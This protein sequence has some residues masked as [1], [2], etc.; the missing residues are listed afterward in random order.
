MLMKFCSRDLTGRQFVSVLAGSSPAGPSPGSARVWPRSPGPAPWAHP[1]RGSRR[2]FWASSSCAGGVR[3]P[4]RVFSSPF[5]PAAPREAFQAPGAADACC[6]ACSPG[7]KG[8]PTQQ[9]KHKAR[10]AAGVRPRACRWRW[11]CRRGQG[12]EKFSSSPRLLLGHAAFIVCARGSPCDAGA[13]SSQEGEQEWTGRVLG[14]GVHPS[15]PWGTT[16]AVLT[17]AVFPEPI[18]RVEVPS[19]GL[20]VTNPAVQL[21]LAQ[22][23]PQVLLTRWWLQPSKEAIRHKVLLRWPTAPLSSAHC[24]FVQLLLPFLHRYF[25]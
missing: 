17:P 8:S 13:R 2:R 7:K 12:L 23:V 19:F 5:P 20:S 14:A 22:R 1:L 15:S 11:L 18:S 4:R 25:P 10:A 21:V 24:S 3:C 16:T 9:A 6:S